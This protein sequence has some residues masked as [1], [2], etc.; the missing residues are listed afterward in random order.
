M[1]KIYMLFLVPLLASWQA[2]ADDNFELSKAAY[3]GDIEKVKAL[4]ESGADVNSWSNLGSHSNTPLMYA[5]YGG[6]YEVAKILIEAGADVN[7]AHDT[8]HTVL[9]HA[10]ES[11]QLRAEVIQLLLDAG[12]NMDYTPLTWAIRYRVAPEI[13]AMLIEAG[14]DV[15]ERDE[16]GTPALNT[17]VRFR[18]NQLI[19]I[20][21]R[22]G[23]EINAA[24]ESSG[25]TALALAV[26]IKD[27]ETVNQLIEA[28]ANLEMTDTWG[29]T[30]LMTAESK[31]Y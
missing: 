14:A 12:V 10:L 1:K 8:T 17:A 6:Y 16:N 3:A 27:I 29:N 23:A 2:A 25:R 18:R 4:L 15:N 7:T 30:P 5:V 24:D 20:I 26:E 13:V 28:G 22:S 9:Y 19:D 31:H 11:Y 21:L